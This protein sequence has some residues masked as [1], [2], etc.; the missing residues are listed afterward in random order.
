MSILTRIQQGRS[1]SLLRRIVVGVRI[2]LGAVFIL[3]GLGKLIPLAAAAES[4][5]VPELFAALVQTQPFWSFI[6]AT[7]FAGGA[8]LLAPRYAHFG[9]LA[10]LPVITCIVVIN[11]SVSA[12]AATIGGTAVILLLVLALLA[13][14][15]ERFQ[16]L[17]AHGLD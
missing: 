8:L 1:K 4:G 13:W 14:D 15:G 6:G 5:P 12:G 16:G 17:F 9:A 3:A 2:L 10:L 7:E 11:F